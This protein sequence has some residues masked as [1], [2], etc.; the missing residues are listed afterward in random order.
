MVAVLL[1]GSGMGAGM[2][3]ETP[4]MPATEAEWVAHWAFYKLTVK[5]RNY[6]RDR[7]DRLVIQNGLLMDVIRSGEMTDGHHT[8]NELYEQRM[9]YNAA[10]FNEWFLHREHDVHK[11]VRH[12][13][14]NLCFGDLIESGG[15]FI[16]VATLPTGQISQH[17]KLEAWNLFRIP[18]RPLPAVWDGHTPAEAIQR[19][20]E[21]LAGPKPSTC[22]ADRWKAQPAYEGIHEGHFFRYGKDG[23][24]EGYCAGWP[25]SPGVRW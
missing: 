18:E 3:D 13:D 21:F 6:E 4:P 17:Y 14:G 1:R 24:Y 20:Q 5:E 11:S 2:N 19:L 7:Y 15:Y 9:L 8:H 23:E 10:L 22:R 25:K 16:V 12:S